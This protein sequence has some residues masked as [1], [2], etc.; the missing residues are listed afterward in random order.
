LSLARALVRTLRLQLR[1]IAPLI[2]VL[3]IAAL[4]AIPLID[5]MTTHWVTRDLNMRA[6]VI[7]TALSDSIAEAV[8]AKRLQQLDP[9][10]KRTLRDEKLMA[11]AIC[12]LDGTMLQRT[13]EFP[14]TL[15]CH[16]AQTIA[17]HDARITLKQGTIHVAVR[18]LESERGVVANMILLHDMGFIE[19][20]SHTVRTYLILIFAALGAV[21]SITAMLVAHLS[22]RNWV[23]SVK[24]ILQGEG[25]HESRRP[26]APELAP[27]QGDLRKMLRQL[28]DEHR[29]AH[30]VGD[31]W[32]AARLRAMLKSDLRD[33]HLIVV[34]N[35]EPYIHE[36]HGAG[37]TL[38]RPAS[39][40]VT[41]IEP[42]MRACS[43]TWIAHGSGSADRE[44]VDSHDRLLVPAYQPAYTLRRLW[45]NKADKVGYYDGFSN[46]GLWP[47]CHIAHVRPVFRQ[48]DWE[49]YKRVNRMFAEAVVAEARSEDPLV[50]VQ[51]YHLALAPRMIRER[52]PHA[53]IISF[54]H[55]PWPNPE[56]FSICPWRE[57]LLHG[58]LGSTIIGFHTRFHC[59]NFM[60]TVDRFLETR[61]EQE[62]STISFLGEQTLVESYP[63]SIHWPSADERAAWPSLADCR[64]SLRERLGVRPDHLIALGLDRFDYTKGIIERMQAVER[65]LEKHPEFIGRFTLVQIAAPT[66]GELVEYQAFR[67]RL[68]ALASEI[69]RR[70]TR[71]N[72]QP[73][74]LIVEH[75]DSDR[76]TSLY[77]GADICLVTSIHDGM[78]LVCKEFIAARD[79]EHGVLVLSQFT[80]ASRELSEAL[81]I[82]P[83]HVEEAADAL[84]TAI[85]MPRVEQRERMQSLR[86][87]VRE[88][89]VYG[90]AGAMLADAARLRLR[91]RVQARVQSHRQRAGRE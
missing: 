76:V 19:R 83:Y 53:T 89:N 31:E 68:E 12:G 9:L 67:N 25:V 32:D 2:L 45:L 22:W 18:H 15:D 37:I 54:W 46:E 35:R 57:E 47:L 34:S 49:C 74:H 29:R 52:L 70:F 23:S 41:A 80:G 59:K 13:E 78:N 7:S 17:E 50:L 56:S 40:L 10:F 72:Y 4:M 36:R 87:I 8:Q 3:L 38:V 60:E 39:G 11:I 75:Q 91:G 64:S 55:I 24:S 88:N 14:P 85:N 66:R 61:I 44:Q 42:I 21:I 16:E 30:A 73:I 6:S 86:A 28:E 79:D 84:M 33:E 5:N 48:S 90:W 51:D 26:S 27:L 63:I 43:G 58:M 71:G 82:N 81:H 69:N 20:R 65:L 62:H 77:R 1:F